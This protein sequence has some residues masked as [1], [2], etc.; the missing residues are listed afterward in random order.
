[1]RVNFCV[2]EELWVQPCAEPVEAE[3]CITVEKGRIDVN[4]AE[5]VSMASGE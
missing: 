4:L 3:K 2:P 1:M 5:Q